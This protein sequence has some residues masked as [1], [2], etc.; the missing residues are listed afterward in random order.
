MEGTEHGNIGFQK[1]FH[2]GQIVDKYKQD[3]DD[4]LNDEKKF[5]EFL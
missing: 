2:P 4:H 5:D 1:P 3:K